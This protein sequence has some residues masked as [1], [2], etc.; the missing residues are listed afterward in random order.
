MMPGDGISDQFGDDLVVVAIR[1][2][3]DV[4][5]TGCRMIDAHSRSRESGLKLRGVFAEV[6][7]QT[8]QPLGLREAQPFAELPRK[9]CNA[10]KMIAKPLPIP[11]VGIGCRV[12]VKHP[13]S[14]LSYFPPH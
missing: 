12:C 6:V 2:P 10:E 3:R 4:I 9:V 11:F 7:Q 8:S 1:Q 14:Y 13:L 5:G